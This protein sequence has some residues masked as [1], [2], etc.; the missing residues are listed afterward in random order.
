MFLDF[1]KWMKECNLKYGSRFRIWM[2]KDLSVFF[3][4]PED[5]KVILSSSEISH[6]AKNYKFMEPWLGQGLLTSG[7]DHWHK[8]RKLLTPA[9]HFR[10]LSEFK[11]Q[12]DDNCNILI[13]KLA[14][15]AD[16]REFDIYPYITLYALDVICETAMGVKRNAQVE[17]D[18]E[19]VK[20]VHT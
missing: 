10:N 2:G 8:Q 18:S 6:K 14:E 17:S 20:A 19:Y 15:M 11:P 5:V 16:G 1:L 9:F 3:S 7:G 13:T 12:I 4:D